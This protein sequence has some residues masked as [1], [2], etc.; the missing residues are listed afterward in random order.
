[1]FIP[2]GN[3]ID[4]DDNEDS[5]TDDPDVWIRSRHHVCERIGGYYSDQEEPVTRVGTVDCST[6]EKSFQRTGEGWSGH[7]DFVSHRQV[8]ARCSE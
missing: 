5:P 3:I 6:S 1:M 2:N 4:D 7:T 8:L